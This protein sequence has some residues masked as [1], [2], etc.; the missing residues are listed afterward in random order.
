MPERPTIV[1]IG[2]PASGKTRIGKRLAARVGT[3]FT[4]TDAV[5]VS[6]YGAIPA[7]F[8]EHGEVYFR[9]K[10][11]EVVHEV[12]AT[13]GVISLG[14]GA[15]T[16]EDTQAEL[17]NK[18]VI[19]LTIDS[20]AVVSRINNSKRPLITSLDAWKELVER[21]RELYAR[22]ADFTVDTSHRSATSVVD[23]ILLWVESDEKEKSQ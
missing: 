10:E 14:G 8:A 9:Q 22:V 19:G 16:D 20:E 6:R 3:T 11:R 12:L 17:R 21:R 23:E 13:S 1:L 4:D 18:T 2:P 5:I 7:L 15:V